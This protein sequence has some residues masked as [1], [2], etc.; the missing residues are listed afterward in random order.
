MK[1]NFDNKTWKEIIDNV[2]GITG[3]ASKQQMQSIMSVLAKVAQD[4][5]YE[6]RTASEQI[7]SFNTSTGQLTKVMIWLN[8]MLLL[9][10][11]LQVIALF[12]HH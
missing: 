5:S 6:L 1:D 2:E 7:Q 11:V 10:A 3:A 9:T 12:F 8:A 4:I